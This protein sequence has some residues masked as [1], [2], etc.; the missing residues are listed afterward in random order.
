MVKFYSWKTPSP[1]ITHYVYNV[2][3]TFKDL[4]PC[5]VWF[6]SQASAS[7]LAHQLVNEGLTDVRIEI[8]AIHG[9]IDTTGTGG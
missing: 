7:E 3:A 6:D 8:H 4:L 1:P 2:K 5:S 9:E